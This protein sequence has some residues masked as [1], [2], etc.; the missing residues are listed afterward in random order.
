MRSSPEPHASARRQPPLCRVRPLCS[1]AA[2]ISIALAAQAAAQ[3]ASDR[4][5][6]P[7]PKIVVRET[8]REIVK[9]RVRLKEIAHTYQGRD[10]GPEQTDR[11][12]RKVRLGRD[13]RVSIQNIAG[14]ITVTA[15]SGDEV[16]I[17]A[18]K[19]DRKGVV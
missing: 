12:S 14:D 18:V 8:V 9:E 15:G 19:R 10:R 4:S 2:A 3:S 16:S 11:F 1:L 5:P 6:D 7:D 17:D 13:G